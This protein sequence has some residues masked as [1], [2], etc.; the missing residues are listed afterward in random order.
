[1]FDKFA[2]GDRKPFVVVAV[3]V[4]VACITVVLVVGGACP[5]GGRGRW[6]GERPV[7]LVRSSGRTDY[8]VGR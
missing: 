6:T 5:G 3:L 8:A 1:V 2:V 4:E 7:S